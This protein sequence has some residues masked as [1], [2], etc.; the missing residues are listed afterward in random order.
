MATTSWINSVWARR[1]LL[2][3]LLIAAWPSWRG[4]TDYQENKSRV[5]LEKTALV[6]AEI[7]VA[8][9]R[10]RDNP[11]AYDSFRDSLLAS[12]NLSRKSFESRISELQE[13]PDRQMAFFKRV[14]SLVDSLVAIED[15]FRIKAES[16]ADSLS[17]GD[18]LTA[19]DSVGVTD[20]ASGP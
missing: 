10:F 20:S 19:A 13:K 5:V 14:G 1:I 11:D 18:S 8:T 17:I 9:A 4:Y 3:V 16:D 2:A 15:S 6:M 12:R 7:W